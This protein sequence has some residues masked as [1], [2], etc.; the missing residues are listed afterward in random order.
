M[1]RPVGE[2]DPDHLD[3][4]VRRE[5]QHEHERRRQVEQAPVSFGVMAGH[6]SPRAEPARVAGWS[7]PRAWRSMSLAASSQEMSFICGLAS[8]MTCLDRI[9]GVVD[10]LEHLQPRALRRVDL[11][12]ERQRVRASGRRPAPWP[13]PMSGRPGVLLSAM[14]ARV[15]RLSALAYTSTW[16]LSE[17]RN[18][19][20]STA[21]STRLVPLRDDDDVATDERGVLPVSTP[22]SRL[23]P[24]SM[25][26]FCCLAQHD[27]EVAG[28]HHA[29][30]ARAE[31]LGERGAVLGLRG[32]V[33]R[34]S[35][36]MVA[37]PLEDRLDV[38]AD[39]RLVTALAW[40]RSCRRTPTSAGRR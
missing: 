6:Q 34:P 32:R 20:K 40:L 16:A 3:E 12:E 13:R 39:E 23:M 11:L 15:V 5:D 31:L 28:A 1:Q 2:R 14:S 33:D 7:A 29:D 36:D 8:A 37:R 24:R 25:V 27:V 26:G 21:S 30:L 22:G 4:R 10:P 38:V 18:F 17:S 9:V 19:M 35:C